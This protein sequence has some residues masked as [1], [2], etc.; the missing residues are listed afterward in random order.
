MRVPAMVVLS[1]FLLSIAPQAMAQTAS[2]AEAE[3]PSIDELRIVG[4]TAAGV[5]L[6]ALGTGVVMGVL[7]QQ[8][9][10]CAKDVLACNKTLANPVVGTELFDVRAEVDQKAMFADISYLVSAASAVVATVGILRGFVFVEEAAVT[11]EPTVAPVAP[12][13]GGA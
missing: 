6:L 7:A 5:S 3:E 12:V 11:A 4:I 13:A 2:V 10:S 8:Q 9:F 1:A